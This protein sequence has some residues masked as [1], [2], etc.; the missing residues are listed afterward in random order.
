MGK[1]AKKSHQR[2]TKRMMFD[3]LIDLFQEY[4]DRSLTYSRIWKE[5]RLTTHPQKMLCGD[6]I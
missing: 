3:A 4:S 1:S 6:I 5:L 2:M